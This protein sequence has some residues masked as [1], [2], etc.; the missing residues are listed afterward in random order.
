MKKKVEAQCLLEMKH[1]TVRYKFSDVSK[2]YTASI[3]SAEGYA[4]QESSK[5]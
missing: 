2:Q 5:K 4:K 3:S 1:R